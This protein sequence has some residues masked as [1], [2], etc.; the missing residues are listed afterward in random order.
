MLPANS[1][2]VLRR[3]HVTDFEAMLPRYEER[4]GWPAERVREERLR[5]L[6]AL[7]ATA[8]ARSPWHRERLTGV[9]VRSFS[10]ADVAKLPVMTKS[11]LMDNFDAIATDRRVTKDLCERHL[12]AVTADS[13]LLEEY[14]VVASGGSSGQRGIFVYGWEAWAICW[15]SMTRFPLR[16]WASDPALAGVSRIAAVVAA[17]KPTHIS[18]AFRH[19]FSG[20][21]TREHVIPVSQPLG[22][23]V[24]SLNRLQPTEL[25]GFSSVLPLLAREALS[26]RLVIS[27]RRV[28]GI[29]EPL[30]PEARA[31]VQDAWAVPVGS[32]YGMS[33]GIFT[34]FCGHGSH[35]PD[36]LC[37]FEP[38]GPDGSAVRPDAAS[39][40]VYVTNLYNHA[41][42]LIRFEV[43][44]EVRVVDQPCPCGSSFRRMAD[45]QGRLDDTFTYAGP[46]TIHPHLFRSVLGQD[47]QIVE[48]QV[49]QTQ[50]G[51][52]IGIVA[53]AGFDAGAAGHAI[54]AALAAAGLEQPHVTVTLQAAVDRQPTGKLKRF[55][56]LPG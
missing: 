25:V 30:L 49:R 44:D 14:H 45:P 23:I 55:V 9:D 56:P 12:S 32:R 4:I 37:L 22:A 11:D 39:H 10:E 38:V 33:E 13:Y 1:G 35:L 21:R 3:R 5:A 7:L 34:G 53:E 43:T 52:D 20:S 48:Y 15:A 28:M 8:V 24:T 50:H 6:R 27:P 42:P 54:E 29:A 2:D 51:A 41:L 46:V 36:D 47:R 26:G 40:R 18:A 31:A 16:D 19:T 17:S